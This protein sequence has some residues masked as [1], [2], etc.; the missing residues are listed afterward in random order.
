M[1]ERIEQ[2][3]VKRKIFIPMLFFIIALISFSYQTNAQGWSTTI[4]LQYSGDCFGWDASNLIK[5]A[6]IAL[7]MSGM[8]MYSTQ[9]ECNTVRNEWMSGSGSF[10]NCTMNFTASPCTFSEGHDE[11]PQIS[12]FDNVK[13]TPFFESKP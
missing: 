2:E 10:F 7:S 6:K 12:I 9:D 4:Q 11:L 5:Q 8:I 3:R 13:G 1:K